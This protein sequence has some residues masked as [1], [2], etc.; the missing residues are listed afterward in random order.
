MLRLYNE[1]KKNLWNVDRCWFK[2]ILI[3][4]EKDIIVN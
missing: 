3:G 4:H 1:K 2:Y